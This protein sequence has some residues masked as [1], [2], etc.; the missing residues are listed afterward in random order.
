MS[1]E[2]FIENGDILVATFDGFLRYDDGTPFK[3]VVETDA[4]VLIRDGANGDDGEEADPLNAWINLAVIVLI[5]SIG[6]QY[7]TK[8]NLI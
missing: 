2:L 7:Y 3:L 5:M 6:V 4:S 8:G 1:T